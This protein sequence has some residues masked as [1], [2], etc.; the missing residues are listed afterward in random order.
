MVQALKGFLQALRLLNRAVESLARMNQPSTSNQR[1]ETDPFAM[2]D[3]KE[4]LPPTP[5]AGSHNF[6]SGQTSLDGLEWRIG[7]ALMHTMLLISRLYYKRGLAREAEYFAQQ[8]GDLAKSLR[9]PGMMSR[10]LAS[11]GEVQLMLGQLKD[12]QETLS[13]AAALVDNVLGVDA[14]ETRRLQGDHF[15]LAELTTDAQ[16]M[17]S[18]AIR[19]IGDAG[20]ALVSADVAE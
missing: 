20:S 16:T 13:D 18:D 6:T 17:Y 5:P 2:S 1:E 10:A 15:L 4:A 11:K 8:V 14:A 7:D 12:A 3:L 9:S 19:I